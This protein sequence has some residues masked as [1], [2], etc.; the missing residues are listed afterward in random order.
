LE[1]QICYSTENVEE[2]NAAH[3][4]GK[5]FGLTGFDRFDCEMRKEFRAQARRMQRKAG[6][7]G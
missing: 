5:G 2:P 7:E 6:K 4:Q 1:A 3:G